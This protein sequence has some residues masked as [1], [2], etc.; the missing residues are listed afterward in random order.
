MGVVT[1]LLVAVCQ[2]APGWGFDN[3]YED[4]MKDFGNFKPQFKKFDSMIGGKISKE[5]H[6]K[7]KLICIVSIIR[8]MVIRFRKQL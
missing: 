2:G 7:T 4:M 5:N 3:S 8:N 1:L 6:T